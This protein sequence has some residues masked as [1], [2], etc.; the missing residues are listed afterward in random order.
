MASAVRSGQAHGDFPAGRAG[1]GARSVPLGLRRR[2][3]VGR[4]A[5]ADPGGGAGE[6][7]PVGSLTSRSAFPF[8]EAAPQAY[9]Q[10][11]AAAPVNPAAKGPSARTL[12]SRAPGGRRLS[13]RPAV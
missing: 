9:A 12:G 5:A 7:D 4:S 1:A 2:R 3:W 6:G 10:G 13:G 8:L 11:P